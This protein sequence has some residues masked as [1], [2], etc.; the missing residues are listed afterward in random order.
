MIY[1]STIPLKRDKSID[2]IGFVIIQQELVNLLKLVPTILHPDEL[3]YLNTLEYS[4]RKSSYLL[5]RIGAKYA[6]SQIFPYNIKMNSYAI[7][8]GVFQFPV[9]EYLPHSEF[10]VSITHCG[11]TCISIAYPEKHPVGVD[12][13]KIDSNKIKAMD[14]LFTKEEIELSRFHVVN[15][16]SAYTLVWTTKESLSKILRT[17]MMIDFKLLEIDTITY[18]DEVYTS[19]F[20]NFNQYKSVSFVLDDYIVSVS[21]P[22]YTE[23]NLDVFLKKIN[24]LSKII[25]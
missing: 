9:I 21:C 13:E 18:K 10:Q 12:I 25:L 23:L 22:K 3:F 8:F 19:T 2:I 15:R 11:N 16:A 7:N 1:K 6:L 4:N 17:G 20:K 14:S 5:G 24:S